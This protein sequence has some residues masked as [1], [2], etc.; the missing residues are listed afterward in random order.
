MMAQCVIHAISNRSLAYDGNVLSAQIMICVRF[1][2]MATNITYGI[3][4][5]E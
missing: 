2:T 4:S 3:V 5:S 1:V